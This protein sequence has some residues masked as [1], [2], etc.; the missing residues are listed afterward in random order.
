MVSFDEIKAKAKKQMDLIKEKTGVDPRIILGILLGAIILTTCG[1]FERYITALV[2]IVLPCYWSLKALDSNEAGDDVQW[3]TY[4][5]V[6]GAFTFI[7]LFAHIILKIIPFYFVLKL[8]FL[9]WCFMPNTRGAEI[10]YN[11][12]I[13]EPFKKYEAYIDKKI[14]KA[15]KKIGK[16]VGIIKK[17]AK[18]KVAENQENILKAGLEAGKALNDIANSQPQESKNEEPTESTRFKDE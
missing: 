9:I 10:I 5:V 6:Y 12:I 7:D 15:G 8:I 2:G 14:K 1:C 13:R 16:A 17:K 18:D 3:L 4:W 11:K